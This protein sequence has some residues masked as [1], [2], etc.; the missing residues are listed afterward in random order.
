MAEGLGRGGFLPHG[1]PLVVNAADEPVA[2]AEPV[3]DEYV[4]QFCQR[5]QHGRCRATACTCCEGSP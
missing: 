3:T 1:Q 5:D 4:C 2:V